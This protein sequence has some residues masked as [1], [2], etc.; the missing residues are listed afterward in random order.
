M[1]ELMIG[2]EIKKQYPDLRRRQRRTPCGWTNLCRGRV[3][4]D[5]SLV[6]KRGEIVGVTGLMG[7]GKTELGRAIAGVD[8][9]DSGEST[10]TRS[11]SAPTLRRTAFARA[12]PTCPRTARAWG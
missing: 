11:A 3:L 10:S 4:N 6:V 12:S 5:V 7:A 2:G 9:F 1:I 8:R